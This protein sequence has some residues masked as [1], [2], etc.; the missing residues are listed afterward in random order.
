[1]K[2]RISKEYHNLV[3]FPG[4]SD[5]KESAYNTGDMVS[6]PGLERSPGEREWLPTPMFL[7]GETHGQKSVVDYSPH[8]VAEILDMTK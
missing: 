6:V 7:P 1:M 2:F 8:G 4:G 5:G 3:G